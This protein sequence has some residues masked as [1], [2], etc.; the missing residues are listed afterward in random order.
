MRNTT[1]RPEALQTGHVKLV[2]PSRTG[3]YQNAKLLLEDD[4]TYQD[5]ISP[6]NPFGDG[7]ASLRIRDILVDKLK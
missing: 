6:K 7:K 1:E 4:K 5:M 2:G 3:I